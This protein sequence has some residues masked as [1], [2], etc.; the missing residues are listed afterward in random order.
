MRA[1]RGGVLLLPL[2][3]ANCAVNP[4]TGRLEF[5][6]ISENQEIRLGRNAAPGVE[7]EFGGVYED[8]EAT[9]YIE[10]VGYR[11]VA[12]CHRPHLQYKFRIL[13]TDVP[14]A[15]AL[16]GGYIYITRGLLVRLTSEAQ[17]AGVLGHE[18]GHVCAR[19]TA[20]RISKALGITFLLQ[21]AIIYADVRDLHPAEVL[22]I[23]IVGNVVAGLIMNGFS[24][25]DEYESDSLG[26]EYAYRA[27]YNPR[28]MIEVLEVL[29]Q[30]EKEQGGLGVPTLF[31]T[32]PKTRDRIRELSAEID[33]LY[34]ERP[35]MQ[36]GEREFRDR[37]A[38]FRNRYR[39]A[40][41]YDDARRAHARRNFAMA[42][43]SI[44]QALRIFPNNSA[45]L[46]ERAA[47]Y[48][49]CG[50][51]DLA[52]ENY[53]KAVETNPNNYEAR[54]GLGDMEMR[55]GNPTEAEKQYRA[56]VAL[57]PESPEAHKALGDALTKLGKTSEARKSYEIQKN[58]ESRKG[59]P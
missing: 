24:R 26:A 4:V 53:K 58:L 12:V 1:L 48:R 27:G 25:V 7:R 30:V 15:F 6:L 39:A 55:H 44:D 20:G 35:D 41:H 34:P 8:W 59:G 57:V 40:R 5:M 19:H 36:H 29:Y 33:E 21:A 18:I 9:S 3:L 28:G 50:R 46:A 37:T 17:L 54:M 38:G 56:A 14:N 2:L 22:A 16:P 23:S 43:N 32:H 10:E 47:I 45:F 49:D 11:L 42:L 52:R 51:P 31:R 13:N